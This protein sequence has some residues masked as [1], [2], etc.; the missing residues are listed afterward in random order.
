LRRSKFAR[1]KTARFL[2]PNSGHARIGTTAKLGELQR[3]TPWVGLWWEH[4]QHHA[5]L[6]TR[7]PLSSGG[8]MLQ[9][10]DCAG[11]RC[12]SC[13]SKRT[14]LQRPGWAANHI[15]FYPFPMTIAEDALSARLPANSCWAYSAKARGRVGLG[16][17]ELS[18]R[19]I[20]HGV[21]V[22][23]KDN[24]MTPDRTPD[25]S[26]SKGA[27]KNIWTTFGRLREDWRLRFSTGWPSGN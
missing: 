15:G 13:G 12:T 7:S 6:H 10:T 5:P 22:M 27:G 17:K 24:K 1:K 4:C 19:Q 11:T 25:L 3:L 8:Q 26:V 16:V 21:K 9:L 14:T 2:W 18:S 20:Q 23:A